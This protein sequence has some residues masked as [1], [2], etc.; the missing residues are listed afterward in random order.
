[1]TPKETVTHFL[2]MWERP[3]GFAQSLHDYFTPDTVYENVG[4]S[5]TIGAEGAVAWLTEAGADPAVFAMRADMLAIAAEGGRVLTERIDHILGQDGE[6]VGVFPV[7]GSFE[8]TDGKITAWRDYFDTAG[9]RDS[10]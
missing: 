2:S 4:I 6:S 1:M 5:K 9:H 8:V 7:M 3:G 10:H